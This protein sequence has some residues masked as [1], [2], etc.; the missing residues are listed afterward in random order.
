MHINIRYFEKKC[1][2]G[3]LDVQRYRLHINTCEI[4]L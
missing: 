2:T 3:I 4:A 1:T